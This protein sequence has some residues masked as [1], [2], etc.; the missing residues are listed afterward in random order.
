MN[1]TTQ[2]NFTVK[3]IILFSPWLPLFFM[4]IF[5]MFILAQFI[6][7]PRFIHLHNSIMMLNNLCFLMLIAVRFFYLI[8][9]RSQNIQYGS[10]GRSLKPGYLIDKPCEQV[11]GR[12]T[13]AGFYFDGNSY[14]EKKTLALPAMTLLYGGLLLALLVGSYDNIHQLSAVLFQGVGNPVS[15]EDRRSYL[16]VVEGSMSTLKGL[17]RLQIKKQILPSVQWPKGAVD[18]VLLDSKDDV[19]ARSTLGRYD[20][21]LIYNDMEYHFSRF[22][23]DI[24]LEISTSN[25]HI[26][27]SDSLKFEPMDVPQGP[28]S[29]SSRFNGERLNWIALLDPARMAI[30]LYGRNKDAVQAEAEIVFRKNNVVKFGNFDVRI[31]GMAHW[32]EIHLVRPRNMIPIYIGGVIA[33]IG[34]LLRL[35]FH[36]QRVWLE[37]TPEGCRAWAVG[38]EAKKL[39]KG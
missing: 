29:Y 30:K 11:R 34:I 4:S 7:L 15:L 16:R 24:I 36:P 31:G 37:D 28:Y 35:L 14:A 1:E 38:V 5:A 22:L 26:E 27:F 2:K 39:L 21:P 10:C 3:R 12:I 19:L 32:S 33:L 9:K 13:D 17:P 8:V 20:S 18:M 25:N 23:F 6:R